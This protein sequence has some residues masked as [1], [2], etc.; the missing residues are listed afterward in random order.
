MEVPMDMKQSLELAVLVIAAI[1]IVASF[2]NM[3]TRERRVRVGYIYNGSGS[4]GEGSYGGSNPSTDTGSS[5]GGHGDHGCSAGGFSSDGGSCGG[6]D[7]G[8]GG[9]GD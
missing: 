1:A 3:L 9:G 2:F 7:G 5:S 6:G 8:G 4:G